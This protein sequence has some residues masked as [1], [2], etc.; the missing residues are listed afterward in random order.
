MKIRKNI[1]L[2]FAATVFFACTPQSEEDEGQIIILKN[3]ASIDQP[4]APIIIPRSFLSS[5]DEIATDE[6]II[7]IFGQ[8][9]I[10]SQLDDL[11]N[12]G[13]WDELSFLH[14][15][16]A[17]T[18]DSL[19]YVWVES[20]AVPDYAYRTNVRFA[21]KMDSGQYQEMQTELRPKDHS[22]ASPTVTYQMEGPAWEN[23]K[24]GF[25][26]YFDPRNGYDIF[27][28][29]TD[30]M[31]LDKVGIE[32]NY[33][34]LQ[35]WG[36][37]V[38]KVGNSLG[39]GAIAMFKNDQLH[40]LGDTDKASYRMITEG[41]VRSIFELRYEGWEVS[42]NSYNLTQQI[43]IWGGQNYYQ[44]EL[45]LEGLQQNE[46]LV[47]GIV[48]MQS[49]SLI[50]FDHQNY[51]ILATHDNQAYNEEILGMALIIPVDQFLSSEEAP[52]EGAGITQTYYAQM[53]TSAD[54]H[55]VFYF[56]A[57]WEL[58]DSNF[59]DV[60]YFKRQLEDA[61]ARLSEPITVDVM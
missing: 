59:A 3:E 49:D 47:T 61:A 28:K 33:H 55:P 40:R 52:E 45:M 36:M 53:K 38:L 26:M 51:Q 16:E 42:G 39:A 57:A 30:Q 43:T 6:K 54:S 11:N 31:V 10:A 60:S 24:V 25:R 5:G 50:A 46:S 27:G 2:L 21:K 48:N 22:K 32:G 15:M 37:D 13:N 34:E 1:T 35:D 44:S 4:D 9:T 23:D 41:P 7:V 56:Y 12:D 19:K 8:D 17:N 18:I 58:Q 29:R 14:T 20:A